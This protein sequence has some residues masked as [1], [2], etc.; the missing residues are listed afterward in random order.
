[1]TLQ[2]SPE[3]GT[4]E[5]LDNR[6][7]GEA[8]DVIAEAFSTHPLL[9]PDPSGGRARLLGR[10]L[11]EAFAEA[12]DARLFGIRHDG[13]LAC[14]AFVYDSAYEPRG[15]K[16]MLFLLRMIRV[17]GWRMTRT[18]GRVL[19]EKP[20]GEERRFELMLLGTRSDCQKLGL[21]RTMM[22][23]IFAFARERG[24]QSVVLGVAKETPAFGFYL[25]EG[26]LVEREI[27]LPTMPLCLLRRPLAEQESQDD[28]ASRE[29]MQ[30]KRMENTG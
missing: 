12:P 4:I 23:H 25:R 14:A 6:S 26:F 29:E 3:S 16:L 1:M 17:A 24:Y 5:T 9:P 15:L 8:L 11:M 20:E 13:R 2:N 21:G 27:A 19:S 30:S 28:A 22:H 10:A 18:F 7:R